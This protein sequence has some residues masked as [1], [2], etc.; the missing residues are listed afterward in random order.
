MAMKQW[1]TPVSIG[2]FTI[3]AVTGLCIFFD[4]EIGLVEP[5]HEWVSWMLVAGVSLHVVANWKQFSSYFSQKPALVIIGLAL[6]VTTVALLPVFGEGEE[7]GEVTGKKVAFALV[8]TPL[9]TVSVVAGMTPEVMVRRLE[10][11]GLKGVT[12]SMTIEQIASNNG[13]EGME[14]MGAVFENYQMPR[15]GDRD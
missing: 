13:R 12:P 15:H 14:V 11:K 10:Q 7:G 5:V 4:V 9:E 6:L 2:A 3:S 8:A 1:A